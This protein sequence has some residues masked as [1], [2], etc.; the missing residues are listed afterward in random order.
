MTNNETILILDFGS[1]YTQLIARKIRELSVYSVIKPYDFPVE[2]IKELKPQG[3]ILSGGPMSVYDDGAPK[4]DKAVFELGAPILGV[5]YGLQ[6]ISEYFGGEVRPA[7]NREY[8]KAG[9][10]ILDRKSALFDGVSDGTTVWMSHGDY[11]TR[12]P[13]NFS[14][15]A[16]TENSPVAAIANDEAKIYGVQFHP[17]VAHSTEGKKILENF[18][19]GICKAA[20]NWTPGNF[21]KEKLQEIR[22]IVGDA[23]VLLALSGGVDSSVAAALLHKALGENLIC[24]HVDNGLMRKNES[25]QIIKMFEENFSLKIIRAD[26][27][28]EFL[29]ALRGVE[30]P[31]RKRKIIGKTFIDVFEREANKFGE[32]KF[33]AQG[34]LYP[35]VI[36]SVPVRG[37][38]VTIKT[39]HNVGGLPEKMNL[40]LLEPFKELFK[41][42]VR[43]IGKEL[44]LP[45]D[46]IGR[47]PFPGPGLAV[48]ILGEITEERLKILR[49]ADEIYIS[50]LRSAGIYDEIWQAFA[51]LLPIKTVGVMGDARTY[52]NVIALRAVTSVDGMTADWYRF[53]YE[54]LENVANKII[55]KVKGVNRVVYDVSSKPPATIEWE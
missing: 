16:R 17:E 54:V 48:R 4:I 50:E 18:A 29:D 9:L 7:E 31:E 19:V 49:D 21:I 14:V 24:V 43:A 32:I 23:K 13:E 33:L 22:E 34:T 47:H 2:K 55:R 10:E 11:V 28:R 51:V 42:E 26:A 20:R 44:G 6:L 39:H 27:E 25:E 30:N 1:Q 37:A 41:D 15:I 5:C 46:F 53:P 35:D 8:G 3:I 45:E 12:L 52:E 38:S 36:E 40:E